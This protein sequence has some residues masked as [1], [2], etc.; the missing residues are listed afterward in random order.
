M[1]KSVSDHWKTRTLVSLQFALLHFLAIDKLECDRPHEKP[2][3]R[4]EPDLVWTHSLISNSK[5]RRLDRQ[6]LVCLHVVG[7]PCDEAPTCPYAHSLG[8]L[9]AGDVLSYPPLN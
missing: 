1:L 2:V 3:F 4:A 8:T 9:V 7:Q 5:C 6:G